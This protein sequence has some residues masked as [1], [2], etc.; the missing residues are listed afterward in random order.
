MADVDCLWDARAV[1]GE[2]PLWVRGQGAL[3]WVDVHGYKVHRLIGDDRTTWQMPESVGCL[4]RRRGGGF[5]AGMK[6]GF[7]YLGEDPTEIEPL[8]GPDA[9]EGDSRFNDGKADAAGRFWAG[10]M[11]ERGDPPI[12]VLYRL[13]PDRRWRAM[14]GGYTVTNG[15]AFSRD[16]RTMYHN[17]TRRGLV[18]RFQLHDDG[19]LGPRRLH[20]R[21][22]A[23]DGRPDGMTVD[24][25]DCLWL[26]HYGGWRVTRFTPAGKVDRVVRLP[27]SSV[28]SCAFGGRDLD[29]LYVTS[30]R[31][32]LDA[33]ALS[34]EPLAGGL[35][36]LRPGVA[37]LPAGE[38]AG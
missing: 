28:T 10:T 20:L 13:D 2:G 37:G 21:I 18:Y 7:A 38:F 26:A 22:P 34:R 24:A 8:G 1:L 32:R 16:G 6:S 12:G 3:Y 27:V 14:D 36:A 35:F 15:P 25:D 23:G 29:V 30:A 33:A 17:D 9:D 19:S 11:H 31:Q 4:A 5:V